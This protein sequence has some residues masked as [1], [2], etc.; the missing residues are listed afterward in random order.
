M[1]IAYFRLFYEL[2]QKH[3]QGVIALS[4]CLRGEIPTALARGEVSKAEAIAKKMLSIYGEGNFYIEIQNHGLDDEIKVL[5]QLVSLAKRLGI[6]LVCT[7]DVH[8]TKKKDSF[9]QDVLTCIQTGKKLYDTDRMKFSTDEFYLKTA[10]EM[11]EIF[12]HFPEAI[13]NTKKIADMCNLELDFSKTFLYSLNISI[14]NGES[15]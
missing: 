13:S 3:S 6:P 4:A 15:I 8:Y 14:L 5:P 2:L 7:N 12:A 1:Y 11:K 9:K 10:D